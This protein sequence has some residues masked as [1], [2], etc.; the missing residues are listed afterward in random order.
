MGREW[1]CLCKDGV[2][3]AKGCTA[4]RTTAETAL[5]LHRQKAP[6]NSVPQ[7]EQTGMEAEEKQDAVSWL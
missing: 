4:G 5:S 7:G 3:Q 1:L 6:S 2:T